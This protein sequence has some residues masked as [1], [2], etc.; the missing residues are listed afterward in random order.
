MVN[1]SLETQVRYVTSA[2]GEPTDV[3]IPLA[4]WQ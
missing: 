2:E 1:L 3:L 4:L